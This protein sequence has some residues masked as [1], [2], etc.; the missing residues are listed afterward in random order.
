M[1]KK[2]VGKSESIWVIETQSSVTGTWSPCLT[3]LDNSPESLQKQYPRLLA[4]HTSR[5]REYVPKE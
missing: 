2:P 1:R 5:L 4:E 3:K